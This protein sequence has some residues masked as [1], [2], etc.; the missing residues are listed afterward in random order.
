MRGFLLP[1]DSSCHLL[2]SLI[3]DVLTGGSCGLFCTLCAFFLLLFLLL[4]SL[5]L[6]LLLLRVWWRPTG[7][8]EAHIHIDDIDGVCVETMRPTAHLET[9]T[10]P[11]TAEKGRPTDESAAQAG[12]HPEGPPILAQHRLGRDQQR[13]RGRV[14]HT[15]EPCRES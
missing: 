5:L 9:H 7:S 14:Q 13:L 6:S 11:L 10:R 3:F 8:Q 4:R 2:L 1:A 12:V 15:R